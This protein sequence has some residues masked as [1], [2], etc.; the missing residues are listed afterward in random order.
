MIDQTAFNDLQEA[1]LIVF[2]PILQWV[3]VF[4]AAGIVALILVVLALALM[5]RMTRE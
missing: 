2:G 3:F 1:F 5:R 4:V